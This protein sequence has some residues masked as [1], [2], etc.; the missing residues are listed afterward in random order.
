MNIPA[1]AAPVV[2]GVIWL[3]GGTAV[4]VR[5]HRRLGVPFWKRI[6]WR[7]LNSQELMQLATLVAA[8]LILFAVA[9][10]ITS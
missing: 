4:M 10:A 3:V 6:P 9:R 7:N 1:I 5:A 8:S 2:G